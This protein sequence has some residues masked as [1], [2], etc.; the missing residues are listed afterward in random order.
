M[1]VE[2]LIFLG[3]FF[4]LPLIERLV[5]RNRRQRPAPPPQTGD[6]LDPMQAPPPKEPR[7]PG[8]PARPVPPP[9]PVPVETRRPDPPAS[10]P[11]VPRVPARRQPAYRSMPAPTPAEMMP[12]EA[13]AAVKARERARVQRAATV[14]ASAAAS[15]R[16]T[17]GVVSRI[18]R[19]P[20][21]LRRAVAVAAVL[22]PCK[23]LESER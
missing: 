2:S 20:Q 13:V 6:A 17:P 9:P 22:A 1:S 14:A 4:L 15:T 3:I 7:R 18:L 23:A 19:N 10:A 11:P 8:P 5:E 12:T 21:S 16:T